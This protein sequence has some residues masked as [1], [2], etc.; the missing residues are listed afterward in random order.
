VLRGQGCQSPPL[1]VQ[2]PVCGSS[3]TRFPNFVIWR[4]GITSY[5]EAAAAT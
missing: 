5:L 2:L 1:A 3:T 4:F